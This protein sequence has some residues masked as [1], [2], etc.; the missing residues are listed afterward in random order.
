VVGVRALAL[1]STPHRTVV[2][3]LAISVVLL[4]GCGGAGSPAGGPSPGASPS[5]DAPPADLLAALA[6]VEPDAANVE[7]FEAL[8]SV[9]TYGETPE[10][11]TRAARIFAQLEFLAREL[12]RLSDDAV[13]DRGP[14]VVAAPTASLASLEFAPLPAEYPNMLGNVE[15]LEIDD[16][17]AAL[18]GMVERYGI[19][20]NIPDQGDATKRDRVLPLDLGTE[21][22]RGNLRWALLETMASFAHDLPWEL[23]RTTAVTDLYLADVVQ[24]SA[25][26]DDTACG[27]VAQDDDGDSLIVLDATGQCSGG[28]RRALPHEFAHAWQRAQRRGWDGAMNSLTDVGDASA[29]YAALAG[30]SPDSP[31]ESPT[32]LTYAT[33]DG[34]IITTAMNVWNGLSLPDGAEVV[35]PTPYALFDGDTLQI[36][37]PSG[38]VGA[39]DVLLQAVALSWAR[40][41]AGVADLWLAD[42]VADSVATEIQEEADRL[43]DLTSQLS[44]EWH[45]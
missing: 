27:Y 45:E 24:A 6:R 3:V 25:A 35:A 1:A 7:R 26:G 37:A 32:A 31:A 36:Y 5:E 17:K 11:A 44:S 20:V 22:N 41:P 8:V 29:A 19:T 12:P 13:V 42:H 30:P 43:T 2:A 34:R 16:L 14:Q 4:A 28:T 39:Y 9:G 38:D 33:P 10:T 15:S 21:E 18:Q 23:V 40:Q